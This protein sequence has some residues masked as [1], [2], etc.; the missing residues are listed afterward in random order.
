M[1]GATG[2][3]R[4]DRNGSSVAELAAAAEVAATTVSERLMYALEMVTELILV[5]LFG[6]GVYHLAGETVALIVNGPASPTAVLGVID[7]ALLLLVV[8]VYRTVI[9]YVERREVLSTAINVGIVA[10]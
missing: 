10:L 1:S 8:G 3:V 9:A 6:A 5:V 2:P 7:A 4:P